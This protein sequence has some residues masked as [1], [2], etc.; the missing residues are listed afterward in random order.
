MGRRRACVRAYPLAGPGSDG[1]APRLRDALAL[2]R[3]GAVTIGSG[4]ATVRSDEDRVVTVDADGRYKCSC[5]W[6]A[7]HSG[8][9]GPCKHVL[10][11]HVVRGHVGRGHDG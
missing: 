4:S 7:R 5:P 6:W 1:D 8:T 3:S 2:V 10:A 9:R 11:V